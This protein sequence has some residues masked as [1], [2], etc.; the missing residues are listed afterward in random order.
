[1]NISKPVEKS[2]HLNHRVNC[3]LYKPG[4][5]AINNTRQSIQVVFA[6][7]KA[8]I[9]VVNTS[10]HA[11]LEAARNLLYDVLPSSFFLGQ[12]PW[13]NSLPVHNMRQCRHVFKMLYVDL[14]EGVNW[15]R[16]IQCSLTDQCNLNLVSSLDTFVSMWKDGSV[17][18]CRGAGY[19]CT[20]VCS[21]ALS[22]IWEK[23]INA[24]M[25]RRQA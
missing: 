15:L 4:V 21:F 7:C 5:Y 18:V 25:P 16:F 12:S 17:D 2:I 9:D 23:A 19:A 8:V 3:G 13:H 11:V 14:F 6:A 22:P 24:I 1:M 10:M 20:C